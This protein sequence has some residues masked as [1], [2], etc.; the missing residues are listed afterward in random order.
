MRCSRRSITILIVI[1]VVTLNYD[2]IQ[3]D[4]FFFNISNYD[5]NPLKSSSGRQRHEKERIMEYGIVSF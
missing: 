4:F 5:K 3:F 1:E 2:L